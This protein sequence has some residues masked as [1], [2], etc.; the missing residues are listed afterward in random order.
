MAATVKKRGHP[1]SV[2]KQ[3]NRL[4]QVAWIPVKANGFHLADTI[5]SHGGSAF[6]FDVVAVLPSL[7]LA[8]SR[9]RGKLFAGIGRDLDVAV[10]LVELFQLLEMIIPRGLVRVPDEL[11]LGEELL[12]V[13][14]ESVVASGLF[15]AVLVSL[16]VSERKEE[17]SVS[18][19][20]KRKEETQDRYH[21][22][23]LPLDPLAE[24]VVLGISVR[25]QEVTVL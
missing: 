17:E 12:T 18:E 14:G 6:A 9:E 20:I 4:R 5:G 25:N 13:V 24:L 15:E 11:D 7:V 21:H 1:L 16:T 3:G 8:P 10:G 2:A 19:T 23:D 22:A